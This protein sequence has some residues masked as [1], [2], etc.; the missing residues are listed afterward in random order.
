[1]SDLIDIEKLSIR[2][3]L[4]L[5]SELWDSIADEELV[6]DLTPEQK[7][8]LDEAIAEYERD[9]SQG[10]TWEELLASVRAPSA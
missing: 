7:R 2:Q 3:R 10:I 8:E 4:D 5:I 1:M 6:D 9:P